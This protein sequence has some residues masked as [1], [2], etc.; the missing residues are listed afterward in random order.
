MSDAKLP[1]YKGFDFTYPEDHVQYEMPHA[2]PQWKE[3]TYEEQ[4][5]YINAWLQHNKE[6]KYVAQLMKPHVWV[7]QYEWEQ[8]I[9]FV[10]KTM[11]DCLRYIRDQEWF[12]EDT[13]TVYDHVVIN[14]HNIQ[15]WE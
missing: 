8:H 1:A 15:E 2:H 6:Q 10:G 3:M 4:T 7:I 13:N 12:D 9:Y 14:I 11:T 5:N